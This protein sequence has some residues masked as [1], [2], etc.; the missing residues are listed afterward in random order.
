MPQVSLNQLIK[1][2]EDLPSL[3]MVTLQVIK[4]TDDPKTTMAD[5]S[6]AISQDQALTAK[7]L[8]LSNS[9][10][11]GFSRTI[12]TIT[13]AVV[14]LGFRSIRDMVFAATVHDYV[15]KEFSG[16]AL[17]KG[18]LWKES[19][20]C[21]MLAKKIS[22]K[23]K[24]R[25]PDEA[26]VAGLLHDIGKVIL[27]M[28]VSDAFGEILQRVNHKKVPF[29][30][31]EEEVLGFNHANVGAKIA[32][33]WNLPVHLVE[34]IEY[35]HNPSSAPNEKILSAIIHLSD[36]LCMTIGVGLGA[37]GMLYPFEEDI[38]NQ[39]KLN[40]QDVERIVAEIADDMENITN[41]VNL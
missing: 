13:D 41:M 20:V 2:V 24:Y 12:S 21:A 35:H 9:A 27:N 8:R 4:L 15:K 37:D 23:V 22:Q 38:L 28:Y 30:Q 19:I 6:E 34:A 39:L 25:N 31:A 17:A 36:V 3:P 16:Y 26:F 32:N 11:Y 33:K 5:L 29:M 40:Q 18:E 14:I 7:I 10:F 1:D